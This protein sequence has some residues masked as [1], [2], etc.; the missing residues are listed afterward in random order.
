M[1]NKGEQLQLLHCVMGILVA[2]IRDCMIPESSDIKQDTTSVIIFSGS[3]C[4][5]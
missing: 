5:V 4:A 1:C 3:G 2:P